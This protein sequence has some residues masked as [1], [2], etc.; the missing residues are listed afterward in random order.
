MISNKTYSRV[1]VFGN[2]I[3]RCPECGHEWTDYGDCHYHDCRY[4]SLDQE[5]ENEAEERAYKITWAELPLDL[6]IA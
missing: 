6:P 2:G 3:D 4:F 1:L 5:M